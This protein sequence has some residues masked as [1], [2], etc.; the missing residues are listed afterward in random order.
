MT[1][2]KRE[3][4]SELV[5]EKIPEYLEL[6]EVFMVIWVTLEKWSG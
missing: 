6:V 2:R 3:D 4:L 1:T 5:N